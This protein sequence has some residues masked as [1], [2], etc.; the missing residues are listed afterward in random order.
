MHVP[1]SQQV[2]VFVLFN[3]TTYKLKSQIQLDINHDNL[4]S[5][6]TL[7]L[8]IGAVFGNPPP[9][10]S[11][12]D[13]SNFVVNR[14]DKD[15]PSAYLVPFGMPSSGPFICIVPKTLF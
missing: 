9:D 3:G 6:A 12:I 10:G 5:F 1:V 11:H 13:L 14:F 8:A 2:S 15:V 7:S 4:T